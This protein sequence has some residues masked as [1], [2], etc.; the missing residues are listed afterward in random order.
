MLWRSHNAYNRTYHKTLVIKDVADPTRATITTAPDAA[1]ISQSYGYDPND[2]DSI[3]A[4]SQKNLDTLS[5]DTD[6]D[7][8]PDGSDDEYGDIFTLS[9]DG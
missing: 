1:K 2:Y 6:G 4:R 5:K 7:A 8:I 3:L 9:Q